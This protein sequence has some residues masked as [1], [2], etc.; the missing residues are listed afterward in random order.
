MM[1]SLKQRLLTGFVVFVAAMI[2]P[3]TFK[4]QGRSYSSENVNYVLV[5]PSP[6]WRVINV[7]GIAHDTTEFSYDD[8]VQ[9]RIRRELVNADASVTEVIQR[10]QHADRAFFRGYVKE[11]VE[12]FR[13]RLNGATYAYEYVTDGKVMA[14]LVYY[15]EASNHVIYRLEFAGSPDQLKNLSA[16]TELIARSFRLK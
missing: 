6:Q 1:R 14:R 16:E 3:S 4:A 9:L 8:A 7:A 10:Q 11:K 12:P 13:G 5:L 15:L 2:F